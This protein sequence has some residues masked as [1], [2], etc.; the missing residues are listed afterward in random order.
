MPFAFEKDALFRVGEWMDYETHAIMVRYLPKSDVVKLK[1]YDHCSCFDSES[2]VFGGSF[3]KDVAE[4][5]ISKIPWD[6]CGSS[7]D[8]EALARGKRDFR[9]PERRV[10]RDD[11]NGAVVALLYSTFLRW[12]ALG[13]PAWKNKK[14]SIKKRRQPAGHVHRLQG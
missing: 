10:A 2:A 3:D 13:K 7:A 6:W 1:V 8:F 11:Y 12:L 9:M 5:R 4:R 14:F